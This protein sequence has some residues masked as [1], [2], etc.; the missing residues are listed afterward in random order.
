MFQ[1]MA[2]CLPPISHN[3]EE[4]KM[5]NTKFIA[6]SAMAAPWAEQLRKDGFCII[7]DATSVD[8]VMTLNRDL[9]TRFV[10]TPFCVGDFYGRHTKRFGSLITKSP[11]VPQFIC[12]PLI[13][14]IAHQ[15]LGPWCDRINLNLTQ[16]IEIYPGA[17]VQLPHRDQDMW[18]GAKG[19]V[20]YLLNVI[21]P[22]NDFSAANGATRI[23]QGTRVVRRRC[24]EI[25]VVHR[26]HSCG[27]A[28]TS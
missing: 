23:W 5:A 27:R 11:L 21:W 22:L 28:C 1:I 20:E 2:R 16:A 24:R 25:G 17:P 10:E 8:S 18:E 13:L 15:I 7:R 14:A 12:H 6:A 9:D 19:H 26:N 3:P 4:N